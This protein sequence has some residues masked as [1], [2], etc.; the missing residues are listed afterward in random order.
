MADVTSLSQHNRHR[1]WGGQCWSPVY[2]VLKPALHRVSTR[3]SLWIWQLGAPP[4]S[5]HATPSL[6]ML[7]VTGRYL[8]SLQSLQSFSQSAEIHHLGTWWDGRFGPVWVLS[9]GSVLN[10]ESISTVSC[11]GQPLHWSPL[12]PLLLHTLLYSGRHNWW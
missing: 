1:S 11:T 12:S 6:S 10:H 8:V 9:Y 3:V 4:I 2:S 5:C 7:G